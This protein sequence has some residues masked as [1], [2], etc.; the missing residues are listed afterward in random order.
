MG[1]RIIP[2]P[3]VRDHGLVWRIA[4]RMAE[5]P[6]HTAE[7]HLA[8]QLRVQIETMQRR[9]ISPDLIEQQRASVE[10]A[11]RRELNHFDATGGAA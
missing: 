6:P 11:V 2:F 5:L 7:K 1:A 10:T 8:Y 9:G 3:R 4:R